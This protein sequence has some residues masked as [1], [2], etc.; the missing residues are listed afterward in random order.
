MTELDVHGVKLS[1]LDVGTGGNPVVLLHAFPLHSGMWEGQVEALSRSHR[2]LALDY[3]GFGGSEPA[4]QGM[5]LD[6]LAKDVAE[7][8]HCKG[9][10]RATFVGLSMGGYVCMAL[11][12]LRPE[13]FAAVVLA[14]TKETADAE[15][16]RANRETY[17]RQAVDK[18][19][20]WVAEEML[21]KLLRPACAAE[22]RKKVQGWILSNRPEGVAAAQRAMAG[23]P[24]STGTLGAMDCP[25][26]V[27]TG[28]EDG[29]TPPADGQRMQRL[30]RAARCVEIPGAG[31]LSNVENPAAFN[32]ALVDF[33]KG[34]RA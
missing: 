9:V 33:L 34:N 24:D 8:L 5:T 7:W 30:L 32:A 19:M 20:A 29:L 3:R 14:D 27:I 10:S 31:H 18:G 11:H 12:R 21:P 25:A 6:V 15:P 28:S 22:V 26:L 2:V 16:A 4:P 23:R 13:L 17:A 1:S